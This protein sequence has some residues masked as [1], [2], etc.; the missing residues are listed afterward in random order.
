MTT[1][2]DRGPGSLHD[3]LQMQGPRT[4]VFAVGGRFQIENLIYIKNKGDFTFAGQTANDIGG[5]HFT[6]EGT[7]A[8]NR[9]YITDSQNM[10][11]RYLDTKHQWEWFFEKGSDGRRAS[12]TTTK[13]YNVIIDHSS[14]GWGSYSFSFAKHNDAADALGKYTLQ[15]SLSHESVRGHNVASVTGQAYS[16]ASTFPPE[17]Q[18]AVWNKIEDL[19]F[20]K[21]AYIGMTHRFP[22]TEGWENGRFRVINNYIYGWGS[23]LNNMSGNARND[24]IG[25]VYQKARHTSAMQ[26]HRMHVINFASNINHNP[27]ELVPSVHIK[28]N[29]VLAND[30]SVYAPATDDNWK[31]MSHWSDT[32][33]GT[34]GTPL[35]TR[36]QRNEPI[37]DG[38]FPITILPADKVK[39][40]V[41][42]NVGANVR[43]R[44]DGSTYYVDPIDQMYIDWAKN[45]EG[46]TFTSN[47]TGDGGLGDPARF[48]YPAYE[49]GSRDLDTWDTDRDGMPNAWEIAHGLNP[50]DAADGNATRVD[51]EIGRYRVVNQAGYTNLE[52]YLAD[53]GGDFHT[54]ARE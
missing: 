33:Y 17:E 51:W 10:I 18:L 4:I 21:N 32:S 47:V 45:G 50:N 54:L 26:L 53:I 44:E 35:A 5:V 13:C 43:F 37:A 23:R 8:D 28:D 36:Y 1:R 30:G 46:P 19:D 7:A 12:F 24:I 2:A 25:N 22:N 16:Y 9:L 20:H 40:D 29:L 48:V 15:R 3:A 27:P 6:S 49:S 41:L 11:F 14:S 52:M 34:A 42:S 38:A 39:G 31:M